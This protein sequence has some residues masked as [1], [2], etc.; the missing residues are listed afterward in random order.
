M[1]AAPRLDDII[2][3]ARGGGRG[4]SVSCRG[5]SARSLLAAKTF[6]ACA[7][8]T[9]IVRRLIR[10]FDTG[11]CALVAAGPPRKSIPQ[12]AQKDPSSARVQFTRVRA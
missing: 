9:P 5:S 10:E 8:V 3:A 7:F 1:Y 6:E 12:R 11:I 4:D 2:Q